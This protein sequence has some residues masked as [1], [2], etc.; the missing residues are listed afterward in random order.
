MVEC[1]F[2]EPDS[3]ICTKDDIVAGIL[4]R[5][6]NCPVNFVTK[7]VRNLIG[8]LDYYTEFPSAP[9]PALDKISGRTLL[10]MRYYKAKRNFFVAQVAKANQ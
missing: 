7:S 6:W 4:T 10:A 1:V 3:V 2:E 9:M 5:F 8:M